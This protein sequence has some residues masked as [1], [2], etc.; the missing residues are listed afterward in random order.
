MSESNGFICQN[1]CTGQKHYAK[2][3][4]TPCYHREYQL[5]NKEHILATRRAW[6]QKNKDKINDYNRDL[7][8]RTKG[9]GDN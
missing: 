2:N 9:K 6:Y 5:R 4:C 3:L 8:A 7:Y 1:G